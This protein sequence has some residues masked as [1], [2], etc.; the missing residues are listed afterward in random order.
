MPL[1]GCCG[2]KRAGVWIRDLEWS[3]LRGRT[4]S[5]TCPYR[6][7][8]GPCR[9]PPGE[10]RRCSTCCRSPQ[11]RGRVS[12]HQRDSWPGLHSILPPPCTALQSQRNTRS[13]PGSGSSHSCCRQHRTLQDSA[14]QSRQLEGETWGWEEEVRW[15]VEK[16]EEMVRGSRE[17]IEDDKAEGEH[18]LPEWGPWWIWKC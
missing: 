13:W 6:C 2:Y 5:L 4:R 3:S 12:L 10:G 17:N 11:D 15:L 8:P 7:R 18:I 9:D 14:P 16:E 1:V